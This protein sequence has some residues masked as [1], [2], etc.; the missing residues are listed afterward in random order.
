LKAQGGDPTRIKEIDGYT[1]FEA[2]WEK[3]PQYKM[4][5]RVPTSSMTAVRTGVEVFWYSNVGPSMDFDTMMGMVKVG[6]W[7][8]M[9]A[10]LV[11]T[12]HIT[13]LTTALWAML[14]SATD[15][16]HLHMPA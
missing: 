8:A 12:S 2:Y 9:R 15:P 16:F 1:Y 5:C 7:P 10:K 13:S 4:L 14:K 6:T 3:N 11:Q